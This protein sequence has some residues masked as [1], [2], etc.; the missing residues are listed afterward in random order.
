M[1]LRDGV[2]T[3][4]DVFRPAAAATAPAILMRTPYLRRTHVLTAF[5]DPLAAAERGYCTVLQDVRGRGG[6]E[7]RFE[8]FVD[9]AADG[10]D[11]V[12]WVA[13]QPWCDGRVVMA[14]HSYI[15]ATQ[16]L[17]ATAAGPALRA[18]APVL[19][20]DDFGEGWSLR[21][22]VREH[23]FLSTW[24]ATSLA[25]PE[26]VWLETPPRAYVDSEGL[27]AIAP[28]SAPWWDD[29][30]PDAYWAERSAAPRAVAVPALSLGGWYDVFVSGTL[31]AFAAR[32]HPHDRL[33]VG[34]WGHDHA[35]G[36]I[37]GERDLGVQG[38]AESIGLADR[39]LD[40]YDHALRGEPSA[41]APVTAYVL[42]ARRWVELPAWPPPQARTRECPLGTG[43]FAVDPEDLPPALGG[44]A[45]RVMVPDAGF[46]PRD[47]RPVAARADVLA[48]PLERGPLTLAGPVTARLRTAAQGGTTRDWTVT[49]CVEDAGGA[50]N[51]LCEGITR[52][53]TDAPEV[54]VPLGDACVA[55]TVGER[56][57]A[58]VAGGADPRWPAPAAPGEQRVLAGS[59]I[60]LTVADL[61]EGA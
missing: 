1:P 41:L 14:G 27:S 36:H 58:L 16:W 34:P 49:L 29:A 30:T 57:V 22:G 11:S 55:L 59:R 37:V 7:G 4:A 3:R 2:V 19:S 15:G 39:I 50:L 24:V 48:L 10:A 13:A 8:P 5:L 46:G 33:I 32:R 56:L 21:N 35:L 25:A 18:I 44:R 42:G 6:S 28:W 12:A 47:Q 43:G 51:N 52:A 54:V 31:R 9:E 40:F 17:A 61:E 38:A 20:A 45:L 60:E 53:R 23:G 26:D